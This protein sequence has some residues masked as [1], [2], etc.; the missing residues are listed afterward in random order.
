MAGATIVE[1]QGLQRAIAAAIEKEERAAGRIVGN[2]L[3][4]TTYVA[5]MRIA[6]KFHQ[7]KSENLA[8]FV[9][10]VKDFQAKFPLMKITILERTVTKPIAKTLNVNVR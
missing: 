7:I 4:I 8:A 1:Q 2:E 3:T 6:G 10:T 9:N 5:V